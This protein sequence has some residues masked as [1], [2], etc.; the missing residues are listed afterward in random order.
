MYRE[1]LF[2]LGWLILSL[3]P[4][5]NTGQNNELVFIFIVNAMFFSLMNLSKTVQVK[6]SLTNSYSRINTLYFLLFVFFCSGFLY[7]GSNQEVYFVT[8]ESST[9]VFSLAIVL[10]VVQV[11]S[12]H[13]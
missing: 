10:F 6:E 2:Y 12:N 13:E 11:W 1:L 5:I 9:A 3:V 8:V 7:F 4:L